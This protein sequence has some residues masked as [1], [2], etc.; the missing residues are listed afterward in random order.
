MIF[1]GFLRRLFLL[2]LFALLSTYPNNANEK[3]LGDKPPNRDGS[4]GTPQ[5]R[6]PA[7]PA[8]KTAHP[9]DPIVD[10]IFEHMRNSVLSLQS[11]SI[12]KDDEGAK[13]LSQLEGII[14]SLHKALTIGRAGLPP[15]IGTRTGRPQRRGISGE[16][17]SSLALNAV[18][19]GRVAGRSDASSGVWELQ[20]ASELKIENEA[21]AISILRDVA[22]DLDIKA[23]QVAPREPW[24]VR[25][26]KADDPASLIKVT[27]RA[28]R[29]GLEVKDYE[30]WYVAKGWANVAAA[31]QRFDN[32]SSPSTKSLAPG[33][34]F[35][36]LR[37][38]EEKTE[39]QPFRFG[40]D[41]Q[42]SRDIDMVVP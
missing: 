13:L 9:V 3:R 40:G 27:V 14:A 15:A 23:K 20:Y 36:W 10:P 34:Y 22:S 41:S 11:S 30:V 12:A 29:A 42:Y 25:S 21:A 32:L 16:Y 19:L 26:A 18:A 17:L 24:R 28:K 33:N 5:K 31:A 37:K 35:L 2:L 38:G 4:S 39:R 1:P 7:A 8:Q 6:K